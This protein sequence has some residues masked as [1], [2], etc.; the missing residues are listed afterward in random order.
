MIRMA[1]ICALTLAAGLCQAAGGAVHL[2]HPV[3]DWKLQS[4]NEKQCV[5]QADSFLAR[6]DAEVL[7]FVPPYGYAQ[8]C[9][10]PNCYGGSEGNGVLTWSMD[11]PEELVC[12]FCKTVVYPNAKYAEDKV[13]TGKNLLG[14]TVTF[15]YYYNEKEK[16]PHFFSTHLWKFKRAWLTARV[17]ECAQAY[18]FTKDDKYARRVA[19]V[20]DKIAQVYP[21]YPVVQNLPRRFTFRE[22]QEPP[23]HWD[24]GK[25][26]YFHNEVPLEVIPAYDLTYGSA[27]Y[28]A[29]TKE[30]GYDV[31]ERVE[32]D[33]LR[34]AT[35]A[36]MKYPDFVS[37][38]IGYSPRSAAL[39]GQVIAEPRYVHWAFGWIEKNLNTGFFRDGMWKEAPSYHYMT[40]GGL[41]S[42]FQVVEGYSDPEG[43]VDPISGRRFDKLDPTKELPLWEKC[44]RAPEVIGYPNGISAVVHD[45]HPYERRATPREATVSTIAPGFGQAS[46]GRGRGANQLQAQLHFSGAHGHAHYD[47]LNFTLFGKERDMCPDLGYTWTQMRYWA[48]STLGHNTVVI[49]RKDQAARKSDGNLLLF[50]PGDQ[51]DPTSL[52]PA[53]VEAD[54]KAGYSNAEGVDLYRRTLVLVPVSEEDAYVVDVFRVRGGKVH[55]W[56]LNGDADHDTVVKASVVME[57]K[58]EWL[59]EEGEEWKEPRTE[60]APHNPYGMVRDVAR[61]ECAEQAVFDYRYAEDAGRGLRVHLLPGGPTELW[62]G[63]SRRCGGWEWAAMGTCARGMTSG[64]RSWWRGVRAR[65]RLRARLWRCMSRMVARSS[66]AR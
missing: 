17:A 40:V 27:A 56:T 45:T 63:R 66:L 6:A 26:N 44:Q 29:L 30:R 46:L 53:L 25:W 47:N 13:L 1:I 64:C 37:N 12:R 28:E 35:E 9:E 10:C 41:K 23:Y 65:G 42:C 34:A 38:V 51:S 48:T 59:L 24:S 39:L 32:K 55:D 62:L 16:A 57:G 19:L 2:K 15:P 61:G 7:A 8:Y 31:R 60:W 54:G 36:A 18:H 11:R 33:F 49:D 52:T 43:Y 14:E 22:S 21:H 20:L 50:F 58:R 5:A 3:V 4:V